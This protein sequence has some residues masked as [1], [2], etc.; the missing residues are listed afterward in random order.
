MTKLYVQSIPG[1]AVL[2]VTLSLVLA[3]GVTLFKDRG[4]KLEKNR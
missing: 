2:M 3:C 4:R 1:A